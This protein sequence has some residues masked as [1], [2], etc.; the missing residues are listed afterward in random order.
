MCQGKPEQEQVLTERIVDLAREYGRYGYRRV[1]ALLRMEGWVV[2]HKRVQRIWRREGL[3]VPNKQPKRARLWLSDGSC[4][5]LRAQHKDHVW[6][7]DFL[8]ERT[9]DSRA[10]RLLTIVDEYTRE[11]LAIDVERK[12]NS[13]DVLERLGW[14]FVHRG[15]PEHIRSDNGPEF[16]AEAVRNWLGRLGVGTLLI[17]P[18]SPWENGYVESFNR[19]AQRRAAGSRDLLHAE[20]GKGS[21]REMA[22][23]LQPEATIQLAGL[24]ATGAG[25]GVVEAGC[26]SLRRPQQPLVSTELLR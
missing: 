18:G 4:I 11:S 26:A 5:R 2:N 8:H 9:H 15:I 7:Y 10:M 16:T 14:L 21:D 22:T 3:Q 17:E 20:G 1:T 13:E 6:A 12:L 24:S 19:Q 25:S 23:A